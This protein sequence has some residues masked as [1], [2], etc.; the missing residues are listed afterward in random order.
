MFRMA[1]TYRTHEAVLQTE[2][3][4]GGRLSLVSLAA[5]RAMTAYPRPTRPRLSN[6]LLRR[7][8]WL[9]TTRPLVLPKQTA[10]PEGV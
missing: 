4:G 7:T 10:C 9:K 8:G 2:K 3:L 5:K 6:Q 1:D